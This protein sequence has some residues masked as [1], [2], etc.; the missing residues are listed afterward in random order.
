MKTEDRPI[1][2]QSPPPRPGPQTPPDGPRQTPPHQSVEHNPYIPKEEHPENA[3]S[4]GRYRLLAPHVMPDGRPLPAGTFV[5]TDT[6]YPWPGRP[7]NMMAGE[8]DAGKEQV[9]KLH[10]DLYGTNAP[11]HEGDVHA[12]QVEDQRVNAQHEVEH[13]SEPVSHQQAWERGHKEFRDQPIT[14]PPHTTRLRPE[15]MITG[16][17]SPNR[18]PAAAVQEP[19]PQTR[20][21]HPTAEQMPRVGDVPPKK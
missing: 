14:D 8:D 3:P 6:S 21:T 5:G 16:D 4:S 9:N 11:W 10:Q 12:A 15:P 13:G 19:G 18:G 7:S 1:S 17:R 20:P 2:E